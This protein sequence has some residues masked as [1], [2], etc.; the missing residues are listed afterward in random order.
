MNTYECVVAIV[1]KKII[2][3]DLVPENKQKIL[4]AVQE[5]CNWRIRPW[6]TFIHHEN[7][8]KN[9]RIRGV[10]D[11]GNSEDQTF[12]FVNQPTITPDYKI[13]ELADGSPHKITEYGIWD[14]PFSGYQVQLIAYQ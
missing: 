12:L 9:L 1:R 3:D 11:L 14:M 2:W 5:W 13:L 8:K 7:T 10:C 4:N 6:V